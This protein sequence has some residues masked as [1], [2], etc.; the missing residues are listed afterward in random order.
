MAMPICVWYPRTHMGTPRMRT[1]REAGNFEY[2]EGSPRSHN[3]IVRILGA[4]Y[5]PRSMGKFNTEYP[6]PR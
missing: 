1:G 3:E 2:G 5:T 6:P 4:T